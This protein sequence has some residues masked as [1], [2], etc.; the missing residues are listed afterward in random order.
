ML[1]HH[2]RHQKRHQKTH[3]WISDQSTRRCF[4]DEERQ[5]ARRSSRGT[6][7]VLRSRNSLA[8][9]AVDPR[10][11]M[12]TTGEKTPRISGKSLETS[13]NARKIPG[14]IIGQMGCGKTMGKPL[15]NPTVLVEKFRWNHSPALRYLAQAA[16]ATAISK[17]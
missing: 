5:P 16:P 8:A 12:I 11:P 6:A 2:K 1:R 17:N 10:A 13:E 14:K 7:K 3:L 15:W 9:S 4:Q